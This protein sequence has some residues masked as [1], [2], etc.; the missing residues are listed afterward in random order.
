[1]LAA[2]T[3]VPRWDDLEMADVLPSVRALQSTHFALYEA[4]ALARDS[5]V[6]A[7]RRD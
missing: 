6:R 4:L 3:F 5:L 2:P 7:D 1:V